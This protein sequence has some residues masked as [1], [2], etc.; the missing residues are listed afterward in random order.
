MHTH[1]HTPACSLALRG[2][3]SSS[4]AWVCETGCRRARPGRASGQT[5][6]GGLLPGHCGLCP[7]R[8]GQ[9]RPVPARHGR[10]ASGALGFRPWPGLP[11]TSRFYSEHP[12]RSVGRGC[13]RSPHPRPPPDTHQ[14]CGSPGNPWTPR[15]CPPASGRPISAEGPAL[16]TPGQGG[17]GP[18]APGSIRRTPR[19]GASMK[20]SCCKWCSF[21]CIQPTSCIFQSIMK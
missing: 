5:S 1:A 17:P 14:P 15:R 21:V 20:Y 12:A 7:G 6:R 13:H 8:P 11:A 9:W 4:L 3:W 16:P 18:R 19:S 2:R 10:A